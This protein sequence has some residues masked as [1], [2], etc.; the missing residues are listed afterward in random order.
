MVHCRCK[1]VLEFDV[2]TV[3]QNYNH[4]KRKSILHAAHFLSPRGL[5]L[6]LTEAVLR[7]SSW[8]LTSIR[9]K[10]RYTRHHVLYS[11]QYCWLS[12]LCTMQVGDWNQSATCN[13]YIT[14]M[15]VLQHCNLLVHSV[16]YLSSSEL[17]VGSLGCRADKDVG[18]EMDRHGKHCRG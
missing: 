5:G 14:Y 16:W 6:P 18:R 7:A 9:R 17:F 12:V 3:A 2:H 11:T 10:N 1:S 4:V 15:F 13:R 8:L